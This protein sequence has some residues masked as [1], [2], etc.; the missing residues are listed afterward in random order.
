MSDIKEI[1]E[2]TAK[3]EVDFLRVIAG[4]IMMDQKRHKKYQKT[5][6]KN[7]GPI[8]TTI[9]IGKRCM[10]SNLLYQYERKGRKCKG[11]PIK[12]WKKQF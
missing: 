1:H 4:Y 11:R 9:K 8:N 2:K 5:T 6:W 12:R 7:I 10:N 3:A